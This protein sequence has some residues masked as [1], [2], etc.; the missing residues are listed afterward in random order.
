M[1]FRNMCDVNFDELAAQYLTMF[2]VGRMKFTGVSKYLPVVLFLIVSYRIGAS[3]S[4]FL[5]HTS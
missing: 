3:L 1:F 5:Y 2:P 4:S